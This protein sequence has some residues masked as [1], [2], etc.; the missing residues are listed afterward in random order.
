MGSPQEENVLL[1]VGK[2]GLLYVLNENNLGGFQQGPGG[3]DAVPAEVNLG[4]G[5]WSK[6]AVWP[7]D[8]GYVYVPT[9]G[10]VGFFNN[11]GSLDVL[12]R[13]VNGSGVVSF[14]MVGQTV[15]SGDTFGYGSGQPIVTSDGTTSGT[16]VVWIIDANNSSGADSQL[17]AFNP[18]P[19]NPGSNGTLE[20]TIWQSPTFTSTVFSEPGVDNGI[21][22]VGAKDDTL[23]GFGALPSGTAALSGSNVNFA[24][25]VVSQSTSGTATFTA[26][27]PTSVT[28]LEIAGSAFT[29]GA[30]SVSLPASLS[31]GQSLTV[32]ITFTPNALGN[33]PG[34]LTANY[35]GATSTISLDGQ[36]ETSSATLAMSPSE[37]NFGLQP[38]AGST[39]SVPVT[40]TN[41]SASA[42]VL[43]G[44]TSPVLPFAATNLPT[45]PLTMD[46][47]GQA[48]TRLP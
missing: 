36:G 31:A 5:V 35:T 3:T 38:I 16:A 39:V 13:T 21:I 22:Y 41:M 25:A 7:G 33:N 40:I 6:P 37:I 17:E 2:Q 46:P 10:T 47:S 32:P 27:A 12:Q 24:S 18:V 23:L 30:P 1:E 45:T 42:I 43:T 19:M 28:S 44:I 26:A 34:Q 48:G 20:E 8:G 14:Q 4:G 9:A 15:N 29:M 11:G